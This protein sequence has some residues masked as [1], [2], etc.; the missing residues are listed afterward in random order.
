MSTT[1]ATIA[2]T[3]V[4]RLGVCGIAGVPFP[5]TELVDN[6]VDGE[7]TVGSL[8]GGS[9]VEDHQFL[10]CLSGRPE[11]QRCGCGDHSRITLSP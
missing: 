3:D 7:L 6:P 11:A 8:P 10:A 9:F 5:G 4:S 2:V 1:N